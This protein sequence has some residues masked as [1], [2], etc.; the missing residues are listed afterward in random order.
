M[1]FRVKLTA[2]ARHEAREILA[3]LREQSAGEAGLRWFEGL[4]GAIASLGEFPSRCAL[5][6]ESEVFPVEVRQLIYGRKPHQYRVLFNVDGHVVWI[7]H[8]R[9]GRRDRLTH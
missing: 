6:P 8:I 9:H 4:K 2:N 5:A 7:L 1:A 3:W